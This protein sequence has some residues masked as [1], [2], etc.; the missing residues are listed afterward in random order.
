MAFRIEH[1]PEVYPEAGD[2]LLWQP[3]RGTQPATLR[4]G[5]VD[6]DATDAGL[7]RLGVCIAAWRC[8]VLSSHMV[9][10]VVPE[11]GARV[12]GRGHSITLLLDFPA[13]FLPEIIGELGPSL[14][15]FRPPP[16]VAPA[17]GFQ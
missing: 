7:R 14:I 10:R 2:C 3:G 15:E 6:L 13:P 17:G 5:Q 11:T 9:S 4:R 16:V 1:D 8:R 12:I